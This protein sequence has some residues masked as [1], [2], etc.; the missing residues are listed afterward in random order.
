MCHELVVISILIHQ[1]ITEALITVMDIWHC[2]ALYIKVWT[3]A[4]ELQLLSVRLT[5]STALQS[6]KWQLIG[7]S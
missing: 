1:R 6:R 2:R 7:I 4:M 3:V 5:T